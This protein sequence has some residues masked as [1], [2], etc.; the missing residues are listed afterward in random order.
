MK[1]IEGGFNQQD[2]DGEFDQCDPQV[3]AALVH[4]MDVI[5][6]GGVTNVA[7]V[8]VHD[9]GEHDFAVGTDQELYTLAGLM[10]SCKA[11]IIHQA[12]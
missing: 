9:D 6:K 1:V 3:L 11:D 5:K 4:A 7:V 10:E 12:E 8:M 2:L